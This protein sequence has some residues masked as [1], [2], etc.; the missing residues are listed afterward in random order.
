MKMGGTDRKSGTRAGMPALA[1][2]CPLFHQKRIA[3]APP[4]HKPITYPTLDVLDKR[5]RK[6][7][8]YKALEMVSPSPYICRSYDPKRC[9][10]NLWD[11]SGSP[12]YKGVIHMKKLIALI[13]TAALAA[14][15]SGGVTYC[16]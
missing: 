9:R 5:V 6:R 11:G 13:T 10:G 3:F 7:V 14:A 8:N 1:T 4:C 2:H 12:A 16:L 15:V